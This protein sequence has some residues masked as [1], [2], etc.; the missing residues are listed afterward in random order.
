MIY[1]TMLLSKKLVHAIFTSVNPLSGCAINVF[2]QEQTQTRRVGGIWAE[3][4]RAGPHCA[5]GGI[6]QTRPRGFLGSSFPHPNTLS[7]CSNWLAA[8]GICC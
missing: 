3:D 2:V 4:S 6:L 8:A 1:L 5:P 7:Y